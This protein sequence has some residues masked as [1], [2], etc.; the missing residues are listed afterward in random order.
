MMPDLAAPPDRPEGGFDLPFRVRLATVLRSCFIQAS[1]NYQTLLGTGFAF[2]ML[3]AFR[4]LNRDDPASIRILA[5][6]HTD[7]FN[8]HPFLATVAAGAL[9]RIEAEG[10]GPDIVRR[11]KNALRGS[12]GSIG[13]Q[14]VWRTWRPACALVGI[15]LL[16]LGA[17]W[18]LAIAAYLVLF[19]SLNV[20]LRWWGLEVGLASGFE[21]G[22]R[23]RSPWLA[24][25]RERGADA[26]AVL[27]GLVIV[28]ALGSFSAGVIGLGANILAA[29][30]GVVLAVWVRPVVW[31]A[32]VLF[33]MIGTAL[34]MML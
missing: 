5:G 32:L 12:L 21:V 15:A 2:V 3:P 20:A 1:W 29:V 8:S 18:W 6:R 30:I 26:G 27:A 11:F 22:S 4:Y 16:L 33:W 31:V 7:L 13:D 10:R 9:I 14:L 17:P 19:N 28:L 34:G 25:L 23:L 24:R